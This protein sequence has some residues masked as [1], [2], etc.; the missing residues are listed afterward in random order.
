V[1]QVRGPA[2]RRARRALLVE[3]DHN[4]RELL[5]G[6]LRLA[7][8]DVVTAGDGSDA[9][10]RLR[11]PD[12]RPDVVLLD[13]VLPRLDGPTTVRAIRRDPALAGLKI[14]AMTGHSPER[15]GLGEGPSGIDRWFNKPLN[16]EV[17]LRDLHQELGN[18]L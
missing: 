18:E 16:P 7:G 2:P 14:F 3:D 17:L 4:E 11:Q 13:M 12:E 5:A 15:F 9:L 8:I 1:E 6:F 10:D